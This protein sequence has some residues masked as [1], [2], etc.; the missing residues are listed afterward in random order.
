M[1]ATTTSVALGLLAAAANAAPFKTSTVKRQDAGKIVAAHFMIGIMQVRESAADYD[2]DMKKAKAAGIDAFALNIAKDD[3]TDAQL[4][5]AYESAAN[6][7]MKVFISFDYNY[8]E[9]GEN[10]AVGAKL[11]EYCSKPGQ[12]QVDGKC[13]ASSFNGDTDA[14]KLFNAKTIRAAAGTDLYLVPNLSPTGIRDATAVDDIDGSF[15]WIGWDSN[16]ANRAPTADANVTTSDFDSKYTEWL[17]GKTYMA[18]VSPWFFTN[19]AS[20]AWVFPGDLLWFRRWNEILALA[21]QMIEIITWNDYGESHYI[22]SDAETSKH[23]DDGSSAWANGFPHDGWL[24]MA[25]PYIAAYKAGSKEV[26]VTEDKLVYWYRP[27][28]KAACGAFDGIDTLQDSVFVVA[29]LASAGKVTVTSGGNTQTFDAPAGASAYQVDMGTGKQTFALARDGADVF[30]GTGTLEI[31]DNCSPVNLNA[32]VGVAKG[33]GSSVPAPAASAEPVSSSAD[34]P[35]ATQVNA[36]S[37][38]APV[39][40]T[41]IP[42]P[43][44]ANSVTPIVLPTSAPMQNATSA[45]ESPVVSA[46][47][48]PAPVTSYEAAPIVTATPTSAQAPGSNAC[49]ATV[50]ASEQIRPTNC[51]SAGQAW[52]GDGDTPSRCDGAPACS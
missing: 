10:D 33:D 34:A 19:F 36:S 30:S 26:S 13:F 3:Y 45:V 25:Q 15:N 38:A 49:T 48:S 23:N 2:E 28:P 52:G 8:F 41:E 7:D 43:S 9:T 18:P 40:A 37:S 50:T 12:L 11:K 51:L 39:N 4:G 20:K 6:N 5:Y 35:Q 47:P 24:E 17:G 44:N 29:L 46:S 21:P 32:F 42:V 16:G 14:T 31:S 27:S 22:G 1:R